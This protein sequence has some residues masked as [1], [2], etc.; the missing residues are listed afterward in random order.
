MC[1]ILFICHEVGEWWTRGMQFK[2]EIMHLFK[3][4]CAIFEP[5]LV[6]RIKVLNTAGQTPDF[7]STL[8]RV[9]QVKT[10]S[11]R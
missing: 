5:L 8:S 10:T 2:R 1:N 3:Y 11:L 9:N 6:T 4:F 7:I